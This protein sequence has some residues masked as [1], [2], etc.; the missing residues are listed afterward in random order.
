MKHK[1]NTSDFIRAMQ[2]MRLS[3]A[4]KGIKDTKEREPSADDMY[5]AIAIRAAD[6]LRGFCKG[7]TECDRCPFFDNLT[8]CGL[9]AKLPDEWRFSPSPE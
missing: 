9:H 7:H 8:G 5:D 4:D 3:K 6:S 2:V 1:E